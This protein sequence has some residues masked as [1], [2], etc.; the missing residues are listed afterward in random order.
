MTCIINSSLKIVRETEITFLL[1][2][3]FFSFK[4]HI[5]IRTQFPQH[6]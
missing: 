5:E 2:K 3:T 1:G 4:Q 6:F